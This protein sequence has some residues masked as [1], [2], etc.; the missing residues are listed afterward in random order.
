MRVTAKQL[1]GHCRVEPGRKVHLSRHDPGWSGGNIFKELTRDELKQRA[2]GFLEGNRLELA[3]AQE[4]LWA[5]DTHS[6]LIVFQA[7]D[8]AGKDGTIKH[9]MS[10]VNPQGCDVRSF[11]QPSK[12]ELDHSFLWRYMKAMPERG[13]IV[14]FNRSHYEDVLVVKVHPELLAN[15]QLPPGPRGKSFWKAR[16]DDINNMEHHLHRNGALILKFFLNVSRREQKKRFL[17]RLDN[18]DKHWKFSMADLAERAFWKQYMRAYEDM[19]T[20]TSTKWAPWHIIPADHKWV[21]RAM[22]S[23]II[24]HSIGKLDLEYPKIS[25]AQRAALAAARRKLR[26]GR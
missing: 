13:K 22:V 20:A 12:E 4:L 2:A 10:G 7:M 5:S 25:A 26:R 9:V 15:S 1:I 16:Y 6:V 23:A 14:I 19:M 17:E 21:T 8:G 24:T 3:E 18:P 11:K